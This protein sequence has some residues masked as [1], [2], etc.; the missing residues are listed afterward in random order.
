MQVQVAT[1]IDEKFACELYLCIGHLCVN[2]RSKKWGFSR[3]KLTMSNIYFIGKQW[4]KH[5]LWY[6][7]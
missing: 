6:T 1:N 5:I 7:C 3:L 2:P 4:D